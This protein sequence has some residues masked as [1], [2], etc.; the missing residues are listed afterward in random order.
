MEITGKMSLNVDSKE[1]IVQFSWKVFPK[2]S[3][4][5]M[6]FVSLNSSEISG[7]EMKYSNRSLLFSSLKSKA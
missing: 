2:I 4:A 1:W 6:Y 3:S 5:A 7:S